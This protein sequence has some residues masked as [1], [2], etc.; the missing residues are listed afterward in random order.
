MREN[1]G[2]LGE[3]Y[4]SHYLVSMGYKIIKT[5]Y[6]TRYG[7]I[8]I[9]AQKRNKLVFIEVK[10]RKSSKFGTPEEA[11]TKLKAV[12]IKRSIF[13]FFRTNK[14]RDWQVDFIAVYVNSFDEVVNL[15]HYK[16]VL[17]F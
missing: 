11:F 16:N 9:I 1:T 6:H 3:L 10:A 13:V 14:T 8:D 7:E 12:R 2:K 15:R 17:S 5:N 4:A